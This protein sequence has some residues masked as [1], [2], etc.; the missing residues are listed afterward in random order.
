MKESLVGT[1]LFKHFLHIK[2]GSWKGLEKVGCQMAEFRDKKDFMQRG[3]T[4]SKPEKVVSVKRKGYN[5]S[6]FR[7]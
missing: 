5:V 1:V 6:T 3:Q 7:F 2:F 4:V